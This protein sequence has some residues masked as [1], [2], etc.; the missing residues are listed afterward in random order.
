MNMK[1]RME[2]TTYECKVVN[3]LNLDE[4]IYYRNV[5]SC[6]SFYDERGKLYQRLKMSDGSE[7]TY[8]KMD[9]EIFRKEWVRI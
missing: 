5:V 6:M 8:N 1:E 2:M 9:W 7:A 3:K 4:C